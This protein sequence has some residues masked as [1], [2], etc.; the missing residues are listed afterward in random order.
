MDNSISISLY[1]RR[2][3][4]MQKL[5]LDDFGIKCDYQPHHCVD[6]YLKSEYLKCIKNYNNHVVETTRHRFREENSFHRAAMGYW[7]VCKGKAILK[8]IHRGRYN[9]WSKVPVICKFLKSDSYFTNFR[10]R[11]GLHMIKTLKP[12][13][14]CLNDCVDTANKDRHNIKM[15]MELLFSNKSEFEK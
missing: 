7:M 9:F 10:N 1:T 14:F 8:I 6:A 3:L 12:K 13:M 15:F 11:R 2:V 5:M 4:K